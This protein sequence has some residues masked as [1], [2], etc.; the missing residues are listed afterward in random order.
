[1][2]ELAPDASCTKLFADVPTFNLEGVSGTATLVDVD[3]G[4]GSLLA[5]TDCGGEPI[6]N[7]GAPFASMGHS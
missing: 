1:L 6:F 2:Y 5:E 7:G 4:N 3:E